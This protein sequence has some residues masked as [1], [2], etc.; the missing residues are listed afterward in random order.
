MGLPAVFDVRR[1]R[2]V[3]PEL[4]PAADVAAQVAR[5]PSGA[6]QYRLGAAMHKNLVATASITVNASPTD[7][8]NALVTP[9]EIKQ[10]MFGTTVVSDWREGSA[11]TWKGEWQGRAYEDRGV[12]LQFKPAR[13]LQ[14]T[15][16]SPLSG[17]PDTPE[18]HHTVTIE[19]TA[20]G[21]GTRV[22]LSQDN[23]ATEQERE[24]S[25][26]NW[27]MML[28]GLKKVVEG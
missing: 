16:F 19:L 20:D 9:A 27:G 4:A 24:H 11:I 21:E 22:A 14:Y 2:W 12:I 28:A 1:K 3:R 18:S 25:E 13:L 10:Y 17:L 23:N 26:K 8:W 5:C 7:V 6:L 15:H